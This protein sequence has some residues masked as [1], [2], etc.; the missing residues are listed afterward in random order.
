MATNNESNKT[1]VTGKHRQSGEVA[2]NANEPTGVQS[3]D[4]KK[5][6]A[7]VNVAVVANKQQTTGKGTFKTSNSSEENN[8]LVQ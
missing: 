6:P 2:E 7:K 4:A 5:K 8:F 3:G 1:A